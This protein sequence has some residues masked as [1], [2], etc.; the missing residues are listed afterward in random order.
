VT[1]P[2][3]KANTTYR[4]PE[5]EQLLDRVTDLIDQARPMP[6][7]TS[8]MINK[9]EILDLLA[10]VRSRLPEELRA[11]RWL[12]KER[13]EFLEKVK[14]EGD[15]ILEAARVRAERMVQRT[16]IVRE[17]QQT[18]QR[19][20][21]EARDEARRLR[22]EAEDYCDQK[23]AAFEIVLERTTKTVQA[24]RE[25]LRVTPL[26]SGSSGELGFPGEAG[27]VEDL[28]DDEAF[29]DQDNL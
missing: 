17:A 18:A 13:E 19:T 14:R 29:F 3:P 24:G 15:E 22:H 23:L 7:S 11:A 2:A 10:E 20:V 6:L 21:D 12:L 9:D 16:E 28:D 26:P 5:V 8:A 25:K 27:A 4:I 1:D